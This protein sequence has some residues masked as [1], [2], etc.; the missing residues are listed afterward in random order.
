M[1]QQTVLARLMVILPQGDWSAA[2]SGDVTFEAD[3]ALG[4]LDAA[5]SRTVSHYSLWRGNTFVA[6]ES[7]SA[8]V[9]VAAGGTFT[10]NQD[11]II[12]NGATS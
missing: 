6:R 7:L 5:N 2:S 10:I 11:T 12:I 8:N 9:V 1:V 3:V 4:V